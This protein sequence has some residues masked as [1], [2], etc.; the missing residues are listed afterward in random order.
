MYHLGVTFPAI[1]CKGEGERLLASILEHDPPRHRIL[2][3]M[4]TVKDMPDMPLDRFNLS[5][6][7]NCGIRA[8]LRKDCKVIACMDADYLM[9][10][11]MLDFVAAATGTK[12]L[13]CQ[14]R[15]ICADEAEAR[16]WMAWKKL[17]PDGICPGSFNALSAE[18]WLRV[19]GWDE[20]AFGWGGDDNLLHMRVQQLGIQTVVDSRFPLVHV[21]HAPR[22][23]RNVCYRSAENMQVGKTPQ[24]NYLVPK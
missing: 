11:G 24:P 12:H 2:V 23:W 3:K 21:Q 6:A 16:L 13:W 15:H 1:G 17:K 20:R 4:V 10:A 7:K 19:G 18:N 5:A 9:P 22:K 14:R 8:L